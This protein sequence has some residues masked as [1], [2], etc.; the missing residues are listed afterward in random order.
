MLQCA[1]SIIIDRKA[2]HSDVAFYGSST[3]SIRSSVKVQ[4]NIPNLRVLRSYKV[5]V[6]FAL[7][8]LLNPNSPTVSCTYCTDIGLEDRSLVANCTARNVRYR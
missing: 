5:F 7:T 6:S 4:T 3:A 8:G 2:L 1:A